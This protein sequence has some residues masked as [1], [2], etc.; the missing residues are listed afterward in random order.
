M[1][2]LPVFCSGAPSLSCEESAELHAH[3]EDQLGKN[4]F[5][6][7]LCNLEKFI[8]EAQLLLTHV[9]LLHHEGQ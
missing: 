4:V 6:N 8:P 7:P 1:Q 9:L 5:Q 3:L 2:T